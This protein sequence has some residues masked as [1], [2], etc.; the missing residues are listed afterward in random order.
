MDF[1]AKSLYYSGTPFS[2]CTR[3]IQDKEIDYDSAWWRSLQQAS[4]IWTNEEARGQ[5]GPWPLVL[6]FVKHFWL[7]A[8]PEKG[9]NNAF[10]YPVGLPYLLVVGHSCIFYA[11]LPVGSSS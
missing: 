5:Y 11:A 10:D 1:V 6:A 9:V 8:V 7:I 4:N 2:G 3:V